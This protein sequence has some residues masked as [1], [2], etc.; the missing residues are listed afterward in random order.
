[1]SII[2]P[3]YAKHG[4]PKLDAESER[5][6]HAV[7]QPGGVRSGLSRRQSLEG[8]LW[9]VGG[10]LVASAR[11]KPPVRAWAVEV[12]DAALGAITLSGHFSEVPG[13]RRALVLVHGLGGCSQSAYLRTLA[14]KAGERTMSTLLVNLRGSDRRGPDLYHAGLWQDLEAALLCRE[15]KGYDELFVVGFSLG[16]HIA[17]RCAAHAHVPQLKGVA[18]LCAP[19][20]LALGAQAFARCPRL[21]VRHVLKGLKAM[22]R[23]VADRWRRLG[24]WSALSVRE[25]DRIRSV[26][27]WDERVIA[28]RRGYA[29]A[30][31]YYRGESVAPH[32]SQIQH[33]TLLVVAEGDPMVPVVTMESALKHR[34]SQVRV[35]RAPRGGHLAFPPHL[36]PFAPGLPRGRGIED[37]VL[38]FLLQ[39]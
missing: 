21:Y 3:V 11:R 34:S 35:H 20:D 12:E 38:D 10:H 26:M 18:A 25:A 9:T 27:E 28:P 30:A 37:G 24:Q 19:L 1:M 32:L 5:S 6:V 15:L 33:R 36:E 7:E 8:H 4:Q 2:C 17:L 23:P 14:L 39:S 13:A 16:G 31:D 22:Y 29:T